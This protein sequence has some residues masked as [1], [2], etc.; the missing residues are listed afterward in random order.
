MPR[1]FDVHCHYMPGVDDG[2]KTEEITSSML[3]LAQDEGIRYI[4]LTPHYREPFFTTPSDKIE[5]GYRKVKRIASALNPKM[6]IFLGNEV[7]YHPDILQWLREGK[8]HT[9]ADSD[10]VLVEFSTGEEFGTIQK[11]ICSMISEGYRPII[12][13]VERCAAFMGKME[14]IEQAIDLGAYI[15]VNAGSFTGEGGFAAKRFVKKLAKERLLD[16]VG[17]DAHDISERKPRMKK[18]AAILK[19][20]N[21]LDYAKQI[22][23]ENP[24]HIVK[25]LEL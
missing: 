17:S 19:K 20:I 12:A 13:H 10:Y 5:E 6:K 14:N 15:Q 23:F 1:F 21:G 22:L 8:V 2:A 24:L 7:H 3:E 11:C 25:N 4:I 9:M 16:F 18:C